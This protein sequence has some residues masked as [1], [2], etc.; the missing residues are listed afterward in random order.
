MNENPLAT[1]ADACCA[2][3][4]ELSAVAAFKNENEE[5]AGAGA[6][7][8]DVI[9]VAF[10]N[11]NALVTVG[12]A[13]AEGSSSPSLVPL[14]SNPPNMMIHSI[15]VQFRSWNDNAM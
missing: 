2:A 15:N 14:I 5:T 8:S 4:Y 3:S 10:K 6:G 7:D 1:G 13:A 9:E 11:P 12:A